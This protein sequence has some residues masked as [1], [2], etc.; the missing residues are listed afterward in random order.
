MVFFFVE[1]FSN[2][3][4]LNSKVIDILRSFN[5]EEM[6]KFSEFLH[7]PFHNKNKK[8]VLLFE[9][10]SKYHP[11]YDNVNLTKE[12]LYLKIFET[13]NLNRNYNDAAVRNLI[14]DLLVLCE[15]FL[16]YINFENEIFSFSE[17]ILKEFS[18]RKLT[19]LFDKRIKLLEDVYNKNFSGSEEDY[20]KKYIIEKLRSA[21][22]QYSDNL[23][24][25]KSNYL[26]NASDNLSYFYLIS[27]FKM[28]NFF[29]WQKQYNSGNEEN[30]AEQILAGISI[31]SILEM[32][33]K[34]SGHDF[35][36]LS[37][38]FKMYL[39]LKNPVSE[40]L[41]FDFKNCLSENAGLFSPLESYGLY[42]CLTNCC[43]QKIDLGMTKYHKECFNVYKEILSH[44]FIDNYP[45]FFPMTTFTAI[46]NTGINSGEYSEVE[47][48]VH[49]YSSRLNPAYKDDAI[50]YFLALINFGRKN[51]R[52]AL[53]HASITDTEFTNFKYHLKII[54]LKSF[55]ELNDFESLYYAADSF[56]HFLS[57]NKL[58]GENY[59][60]EF[61]KF[62]KVLDMLVKFRME[63]KPGLADR[64][65][66]FLKNNSFTGK[67]WIDEKFKQI[68]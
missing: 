33:N 52:E 29:E 15:K 63:K 36:I 13:G 3:F 59:R 17:Q 21:N 26:I 10:L 38:Y 27:I 28:I 43:T 64:I 5:R 2:N 54:S 55:Y 45:G 44:K 6:K 34:K 39:A 35:L 19:V 58:V 56:S 9:L 18:E 42:I 68:N 51:F 48:F 22:S 46:V 32:I 41:Y 12:N 60:N 30:I 67:N 7:S 25:F 66:Y 14:S 8:A 23:N 53:K 31:P 57:K 49:E 50:N 1:L 20:F 65:N 4:M 24:F 62:I 47:N 40:D 16:A 37:V 61:R 11:G